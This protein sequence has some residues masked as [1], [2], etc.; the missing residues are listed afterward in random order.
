M[1]LLFL[2]KVQIPL[3]SVIIIDDD[4]TC[5][6]SVFNLVTIS[7]SMQL[8]THISHCLNIDGP[9]YINAF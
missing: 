7:I 6:Q 3:A 9:P 1:C 4:M 2:K 8:V 5:Y